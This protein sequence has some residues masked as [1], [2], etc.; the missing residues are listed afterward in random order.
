MPHTSRSFR[1]AA[2][3]LSALAAFALWLPTLS[4]PSAHAEAALRAPAVSLPELA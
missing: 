4:V 1:P 3:L 2:A